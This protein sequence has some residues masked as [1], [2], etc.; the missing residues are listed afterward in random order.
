MRDRPPMSKPARRRRCHRRSR[1]PYRHP[2]DFGAG[3]R[4]FSFGFAVLASAG[5][6]AVL[7]AT[8]WNRWVGTSTRQVT[9]EAYVR[10]D[11]TPLSAKIEGYVR[12]VR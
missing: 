9:H 2:C 7:F 10:G 1:I 3:P 11:I 5:I 4:V 8:Q 6:I 12:T